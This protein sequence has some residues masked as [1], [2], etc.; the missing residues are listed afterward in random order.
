MFIT[1]VQVINS[2]LSCLGDS[3]ITDLQEDHAY[4]DLILQFLGEVTDETLARGWWFNQEYTRLYPD[5]NSKFIYVPQDIYDIQ[6]LHHRGFSV[7]QMGRRMYD[8]RRRTYE[9]NHP[10]NVKL[11]RKFD[12]EDLPY[13]A[14]RAIRDGTIVRFQGRVD[15]DRETKYDAEKVYEFSK[16]ELMRK[17]ANHQ[18]HNMLHRPGMEINAFDAVAIG[19]GDNSPFPGPNYIVH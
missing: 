11:I 6:P 8:A 10:L 15:A 5:A 9:W 17:D 12:F 2:C 3:G 14:Q 19:M 4:K 1:K 18:K 7:T 16:H 13:D